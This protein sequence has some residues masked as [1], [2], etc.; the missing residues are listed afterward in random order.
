MSTSRK[1]N[2]FCSFIHAGLISPGVNPKLFRSCFVVLVSCGT[3]IAWK[4][5]TKSRKKSFIKLYIPETFLK[6]KL[7]FF[8]DFKKLDSVKNAFWLSRGTFWAKEEVWSLSIFSYVFV[9]FSLK[10]S[11][12]LSKLL[13]TCPEDHFEPI[14]SF[15][16]ISQLRQPVLAIRLRKKSAY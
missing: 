1:I 11:A 10:V 2:T 8:G 3:K 15:S 6:Y 13:P 4:I 12:G 16:K 9:T 5:D 14:V 7:Y